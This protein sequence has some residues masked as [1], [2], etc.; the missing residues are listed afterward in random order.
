MHMYVSTT[1]HKIRHL[2]VWVISI[3]IGLKRMS[4]RDFSAFGI[5]PMG[6]SLKIGNVCCWFSFLHFLL[7]LKWCDRLNWL[8][9]NPFPFGCFVS[10]WC[11]KI[12]TSF[13]TFKIHM[14]VSTVHSV[15][16]WKKKNCW[17]FRQVPN[18]PQN[19]LAT[20]FRYKSTHLSAMFANIP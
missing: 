12:K 10:C 11:S 5:K 20:D 8:L 2:G 18:E 3:E 16:E 17:I 9:S 7:L 13:S 19:W 6:Q 1:V 14:Y 15:H 4:C